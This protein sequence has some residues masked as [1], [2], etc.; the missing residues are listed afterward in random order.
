[1]ANP[2]HGALDSRRFLF[3]TGKGGVGKTTVCAALA[4]ALAGRGKR[5]LIAMTGV[6]ER[7]SSLLGS[8]AIGHDIQRVATNVWASKM[9]PEQAMEEYGLLVLKV[10]ALSRRLFDNK[11]TNG[12]FRA[13]PGL[14][15]WALLGKAWYH[16]TETRDDGSWL[17]D[18]VLFDAPSTGHGLD[19]LRVPKVLV[20]LAPPGVLRRDAER[21]WALF[22][23][24]ERSGVV[25]TTLPQAMPISEACELV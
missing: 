14:F 20:E 21:A 7:L 18:V 17:Y 9:E 16:T 6:Q 23:D 22:K 8:A 1:M 5:V 25:I 11:Y 10:R 19:M 12:F 2:P 24:A 3:V 15:D 4:L 13:V